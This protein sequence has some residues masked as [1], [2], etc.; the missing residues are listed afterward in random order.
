MAEPQQSSFSWFIGQAFG[1]D[2]LTPYT[3][4]YAWNS[5]QMAHAMMGFCIAVCWLLFIIALRPG[6]EPRP[7]TKEKTVESAKDDDS[8]FETIFRWLQRRPMWVY[9]VFLFA[10]IPLKEVADILLDMGNYS[11]SPVKPNM[12]RLVFDSVTD[13]SFWWS[14]MFLAAALIGWFIEGRWYRGGIPTVGLLLCILFWWQF[15][16]PLWLNQKRTFDRSGMPFN[17]TRLVVQSGRNVIPFQND[18]TEEWKHLED[19]RNAVVAT[20][21]P[22]KP[23]QKHFIIFGGLPEDRSRLAVGMGCE[24]AFKLRRGDEKATGDDLIRVQYASASV[25]LER[26]QSLLVAKRERLECVVI[27]E[28]DVSIRRPSQIDPETRL[29]FY[30][31]TAK[32]VPRKGVRVPKELLESLKLDKIPG[33]NTPLAN[34]PKM[35]E[36]DNIEIGK[37]RDKLGKK[38]SETSNDLAARLEIFRELGHLAHDAKVSTI[39]VLGGYAGPEGS[40]TRK[41]WEKQRDQWIT[42][43]ATLLEVDEKEL[44]KIELKD[45]ER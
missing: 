31:N 30:E 37:I 42:E 19:F 27:D 9:V 7:T 45:R 39:W 3:A 38:K 35:V 28:L 23:P 16:A 40:E 15:A 8:I 44:R 25:V 12:P 34:A 2:E 21:H 29:Y 17:Y 32:A 11:G 14:G 10:M 13:I 36:I 41:Q 33:L 5:N 26:P 20:E 43:I 6:E 4:E 18:A 1:S 24:F 22:N